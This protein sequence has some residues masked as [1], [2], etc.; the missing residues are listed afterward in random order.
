MADPIRIDGLNSTAIPTL[1]H[2]FPAMKDG[3]TVKLTVDQVKVLALAGLAAPSVS[4]DPAAS[5][6][7]A[8]DVQAAI[9]EIFSNPTQSS[10]ALN[11]QGAD[12]LSAATTDLATTTGV[13]V[14]V[15]G[16]ATIT[17]FGT[18][19]AGA[20]RI[21]RFTGSPTLTHNA[22]S[23]ILP[24][25]IDIKAAPGDVA[26]MRS[27]GAG[28]WFCQ[29]YLRATGF[30]GAI[31]KLTVNES[32]PD[33]IA[34]IIPW[35]AEVEDLGGWW[36]IGSPT[37]LTVPAGVNRVVVK[38]AL[39]WAAVTAG[40]RRVKILKNGVDFDGTAESIIGGTSIGSSQNL[41]SA[42]VPVTPGDYFEFQVYQNSGANLNVLAAGQTFFS[43]K[44]VRG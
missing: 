37:R 2:E 10:D 7:T 19:P 40:S 32:I 4:F 26:V 44:A 34:T 23:L 5:P 6:L 12:I 31:V 35:D 21:L 20:E 16:S 30:E 3:I 25:G 43:I 41:V 28:N 22:V 27:L 1:L 15:T 8:T 38:T 33:A 11:A 9:D 42:D 29:N 13:S 18:L 17:A 14:N 24:D 36:V 39:A